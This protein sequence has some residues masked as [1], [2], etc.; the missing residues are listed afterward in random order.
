[1]ENKYYSLTEELKE[2][3]R[4]DDQFIHIIDGLSLEDLMLLKIESASKYVRGKLYGMKFYFNLVPIMRAAL[5]RYC[6][7]KFNKTAHAANF[8]G[9]TQK[10]YEILLTEE[11]LRE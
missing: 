3:K 5:L 8:L 1:M 4:I 9:L 2:S 11:G 6:N 10:K 7:K